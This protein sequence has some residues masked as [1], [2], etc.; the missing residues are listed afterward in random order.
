MT[1]KDAIIATAKAW[2]VILIF[3]GLLFTTFMFPDIMTP[4]WIAVITS[5]LVYVTYRFNLEN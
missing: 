4:C 3:I 2:L 1:K 5:F